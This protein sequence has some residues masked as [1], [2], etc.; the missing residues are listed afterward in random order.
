[1]NTQPRETPLTK[2]D[3]I[4]IAQ[5]DHVLE[6]K[7][8]PDKDAPIGRLCLKI[9]RAAHE[10][11]DRFVQ[12]LQ[13]RLMARIERR[14][15]VSVRQRAA[16]QWQWMF[17]TQ[18]KRWRAGLAAALIAA[19]VFVLAGSAI[20]QVR[21]RSIAP[22]EVSMVPTI[23]P[24]AL[25]PAPQGPRW[26]ELDDLRQRLG[27][28]L[29]LPGW[30][31]PGCMEEERIFQDGPRVVNM[32]YSCVTMTLRAGGV[33]IPAV[34]QG[35]VQDV[36][37]AGRPGVYI[38]GAWKQGADGSTTWSRGSTELIFERD[39][40]L[41]ILRTIPGDRAVP[42]GDGSVRRIPNV[43]HLDVNDLIRIAESLTP[44]P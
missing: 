21:S 35:S 31:P 10:P 43:W 28:P 1:M 29:L 7:T 39:G 14:E 11:S 42:N 13:T 24:A 44:L 8:N 27:G 18:R 25:Q 23:S 33:A 30:L 16:A 34:A 9:V 38:D 20:A 3:R 6:D 17:T 37:I 41:V 19:T 32:V 12:D 2:R 5:I 26:M 15:Q 4:L 22:R 40:V 36:M